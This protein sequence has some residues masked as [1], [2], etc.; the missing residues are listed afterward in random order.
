[1]LGAQVPK[2]QRLFLVVLGL[3][4]YLGRRYVVMLGHSGAEG[5]SGDLKFWESKFEVTY[6]AHRL[7]RLVRQVL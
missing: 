1:M 5:K 6:M 4:A 3:M 2:G 7:S